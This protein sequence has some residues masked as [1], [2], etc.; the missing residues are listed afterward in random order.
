MS[1][2]CENCR[3]QIIKY[4]LLDVSEFQDYG[5]DSEGIKFENV[6]LCIDCWTSAKQNS[7]ILHV[8]SK[9]EI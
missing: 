9:K 4:V 1:E 3:K 7:R 6:T 5:D 8:L 2:K